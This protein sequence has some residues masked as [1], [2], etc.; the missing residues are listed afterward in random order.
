M[1]KENTFDIMENQ[2]IIR[3][4]YEQLHAKI[5]DNLGEMRKIPKNIQLT[6][7]ELERNRKSE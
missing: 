5:L 1:K 2:K 4:C 3:G 6:M 7:T